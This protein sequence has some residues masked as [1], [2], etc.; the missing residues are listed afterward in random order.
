M[1][2][3]SNTVN[4]AY[5][6]VAD[7]ILD[8]QTF[9]IS[10]SKGIGRIVFLIAFCSAL[11]NYALTGTGLKENLI[12]IFKATV[13]FMIVISFY[14]RIIGWITSYTYSLAEDSIYPSVREY[15]YET[16]NKT[17]DYVDYNSKGRNYVNKTIS[18][19]ISTSDT[20]LIFYDKGNLSTKRE[21]KVM[22]YQTVTPATVLQVLFLTA[23]ECFN[24][25]EYSEGFSLSNIGT[26]L[27]N[28]AKGVFCGFVIIFTG[29][30]ALLEYLICFLEFMLVA[31]VGVILFPM[32][33]WEGSK[34]MTESFIKAILGFFMKL[35]FCNLA[36]F[37]LIYGFVSLLKIISQ[38]GFIG[39]VDQIVF[40]IFVCALFF[41][42]CKSAPGIAQSLLSGSPSLSA[43]G[44]ISAVTGAVA[45]T[46]SVVKL[47][48]KV[49]NV[50]D[51]VAGVA[52]GGVIGGV[53][54][55]KEAN[56]ARHSAMDAVKEAGGNEKQQKSAGRKAF[57]SS[58]ASD[59]G[60]AAK[61]A[62]LGL[63]RSLLGQNGR[64][65]SAGGGTNPHSWLQDFKNDHSQS[66]GE[67][68]DN[69]RDE[70]RRRG[71]ASADKFISND[72]QLSANRERQADPDYKS[73]LD[74]LN[75]DFPGP[76]KNDIK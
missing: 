75:K 5:F 54:S 29:V 14:P 26:G 10:Q 46:R 25:A 31:S 65:G 70:G 32:S 52:T 64:G 44:A 42:I 9:F 60:D 51:K 35:L 45:A 8:L 48:G 53:G 33:I 1:G 41:Y 43:S 47:A 63:T 24:Y 76:S 49:A 12:K 23:S 20:H 6:F 57:G 73:S 7:K 66:L 30:F 38:T 11:L 21:H 15:F 19:V 74:E 69:R 13:F 37:L 58:L 50:G 62:G 56:A 55:L 18:Q 39:T 34:F 71:E 40:I 61:S 2:N 36:I 3:F 68:M 59:A 4:N 16:T 67:H 27:A 72:K 28:F 17:L 22:N